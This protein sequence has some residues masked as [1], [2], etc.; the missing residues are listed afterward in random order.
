MP[1]S[2]TANSTASNC[3]KSCCCRFT[4]IISKAEPPTTRRVRRSSTMFAA[5][6]WCVRPKAGR[7]R[8][9]HVTWN[10][11]GQKSGSVTSLNDGMLTREPAT[12]EERTSYRYP[13]PGWMLGVVGFGPHNQPDPARRVLTFT[14]APL[15]RDLEIAGPIK[16]TLHAASTCNDMDFFV[17]ISE[18]MP[19]RRRIAPRASI[20]VHSD[21]EGLAARLASRAR[22]A[23]IDRHGALPYP[24]QSGTDRARENLPSRYFGRADGAPLQGWQP[25]PVGNRQRRFRR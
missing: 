24:R 17:K 23:K 3:T 12:G 1:S 16:L 18:Q 22:S 4:I 8:A 25:R 5:P 11:S 15:Q 19:H 13:D 21:H 10:L 20:R 7:R 14:T 6:M 9:R 2:P